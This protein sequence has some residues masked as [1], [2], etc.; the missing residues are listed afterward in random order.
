MSHKG[1]GVLTS[2]GVSVEVVL[3]EETPADIAEMLA[4]WSVECFGSALT[5]LEWSEPEWRMLVKNDG[6]LVSHLGI[7][8]RDVFA[9]ESRVRIAGICNVMTPKEWRGRGYASAAMCAAADFMAATLRAD[10]GLLLCEKHLVGLYESLGWKS[11]KGAVS[12]EQPDG[13]RLWTH[14]AMVLPFGFKEWPEGD[15]DLRGLPW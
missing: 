4:Q 9:G 1:V 13:K 5:E 14:E 8:E 11:V 10:F 7:V 15:V 6:K 12:F 3:K 2:N